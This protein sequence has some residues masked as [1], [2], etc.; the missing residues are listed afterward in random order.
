MKAT[1]TFTTTSGPELLSTY[2]TV[3]KP[4]KRLLWLIKCDLTRNSP[5]L[6]SLTSFEG[7]SAYGPNSALSTTVTHS[8]HSMILL[9]RIAWEKN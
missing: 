3:R 9:P 1:A 8:Q 6:N 4:E 5:K 2:S 7:I